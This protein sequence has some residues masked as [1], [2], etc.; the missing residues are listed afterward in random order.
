MKNPS[1]STL[2]T[3][4]SVEQPIKVDTVTEQQSS[5]NPDTKRPT[6]ENTLDIPAWTFDFSAIEALTSEELVKSINVAI[7]E[8]RFF[9]PKENNALFFLSNLKSIDENNENIPELIKILTD[10]ISSQTQIALQENDDKRLVKIISRLKT[11][12][13]DENEIKLLKEKLAN[14]KTINKLYAKGIKLI[15]NNRIVND[16]SNDAWHIAKQMLTVN[17]ENI[18]TK[19]LVNQ[20]NHELLNNALRAAEEI[21]FEMANTHITQAQL[22][23]PNSESVLFAIDT[24]KQLKLQRYQWLE[25]QI[26]QAI[27]KV[28]PRHDKRS[29]TSPCSEGSISDTCTATY[30][31][32]AA[33]I[34]DVPLDL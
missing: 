27:E 24:I 25:K 23:S 10:K 14:I 32:N 30:P 6:I 22:L 7:Q 20:V 11:L 16:D 9:Q 21:D 33:A 2:L 12:S 15:N 28:K 13:F 8:E 29:D 1:D 17:S 34:S 19:D 26:S 31:A 4:S 18:K 3:E 5:F